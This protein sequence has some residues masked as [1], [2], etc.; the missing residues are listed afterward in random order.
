MPELN[1]EV[2]VIYLH[3]P[4]GERFALKAFWKLE[5]AQA[6]VE[7]ITN[8]IQCGCDR[9]GEG[10]LIPAKVLGVSAVTIVRIPIE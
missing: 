9:C 7:K 5:C 3:M 2:F 10:E 6:H 1:H 8:P 4:G